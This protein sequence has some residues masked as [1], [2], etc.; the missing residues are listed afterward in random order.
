MNDLAGD[1]QAHGLKR[2][3]EANPEFQGGLLPAGD[4]VR[5]ECVILESAKRSDPLRHG[6]RS[7]DQSDRSATQFLCA[8]FCVTLHRLPVGHVK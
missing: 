4:N 3:V 5:N 2:L 6:G 8:F 1:F 7:P